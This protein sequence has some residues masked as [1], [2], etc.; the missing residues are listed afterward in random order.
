LIARAPLELLAPFFQEGMVKSG[1]LKGN[2]K[3]RIEKGRPLITGNIAMKKGVFTYEEIESDIGPIDIELMMLGDS[4][5]FK[6]LTGAWGKG[7]FNG[8]GYAVWNSKGITDLQVGINSK[9]IEVEMPDLII[10]TAETGKFHLSNQKDGFLLS[11]KVDLGNT[12][13]IRDIKIGDLVQPLQPVYAT[14]TQDSSLLDKLKFQI[15]V[16]LLENVKV[17][18]NLGHLDLDGQFTI[19]GTAVKPSYTG[20][21]HV[22]EGYV[23]YFD[24]KFEISK[25]TFYNYDP[26][27]LNPLI[28]LKAT[29][30]VISVTSGGSGLKTFETYTISMSL[31]GNLREPVVRLWAEGTP[32]NEADIISI[33]TLGQPLGAI[34]GDLGERLRAFAGQSLVGFGARKLEQLLGF[35]QIDIQGDIFNFGTNPEDSPRLTLTKWITPR[36]LLS[37]ETALGDLTKPNVSAFLRLTKRLFLEGQASMD[38][39]GLDLLFKYSR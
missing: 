18:M 14:A 20:E 2:G 19:T 39:Y 5:V 6:H 23:L 21:F 16:N 35:E 30:E 37:Y 25:G 22:T 27:D 32:L 4:L 17:D 38:D 3:V 1:E 15:D 29:T 12:R 36:I 26:Y 11:G 34:G 10:V 9:E 8:N 33:L 24:R 28:D 13:F 7:S 31:Q